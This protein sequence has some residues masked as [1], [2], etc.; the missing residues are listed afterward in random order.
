MLVDIGYRQTHTEIQSTEV[1]IHNET[2]AIPKMLVSYGW[3]VFHIHTGEH[4]S[5]RATTE[6]C[7]IKTLMNY[8]ACQ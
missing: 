8:N 3:S 7:Y 6:F 1:N 5:G 2:D 4:P